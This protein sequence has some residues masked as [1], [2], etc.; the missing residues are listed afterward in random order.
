[1]KLDPGI[2]AYLQRLS[3]VTGGKTA[4]Y[5]PDSRR[6]MLRQRTAAFPVEI[7]ENVAF[8]DWH[9]AAPGRE[10]PIRI[11]RPAQPEPLPA[12]LY[13]HG[14]GW[15]GGDI[16]THH[17]TTAILADLT[18][19]IVVSVHYRRPPENPYPAAL[20]DAEAAFAWLT[21]P[22]D[23]LGIDPTRLAAGGDSAGGNLTAALAL[24]LRDAGG[25]QLRHQFLIYPVLDT[26]FETASYRAA[27]DPI[28]TPQAMR[29][30]WDAYLS[31]EDDKIDPYAVPMRAGDLSGLPP[32]TVL[33]AEADPL[34][35]EGE[36]YAARL[37]EAGV[38]TTL[39]RGE[40]MVHGFLRA[41]ELSPAVR[42]LFAEACANLARD[43]A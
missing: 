30:Y 28:L 23:W 40:G 13:F 26:D 24:K 25:P 43:L 35:D 7:P 34:R 29:Y 2:A 1:M 20:E 4:A 6:R 14:G 12:I 27:A 36:A 11:Y 22:P 39:L 41:W 15:V 10:I 38:A 16:L 5:D 3:E 42:A 19:A 33:T 21:K 8:E 37:Q 18:G 17:A 31:R 32:A 9:I